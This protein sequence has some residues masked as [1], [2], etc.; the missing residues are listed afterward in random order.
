MEILQ[1]FEVSGYAQIKR[2]RRGG[3]WKFKL[4]NLFNS[5]SKLAE[6]G[7]GPPGK[8]HY[9]SDPPN[10]KLS[11]PRMQVQ[12]W[13]APESYQTIATNFPSHIS[14]IITLMKI[15]GRIKKKQQKVMRLFELKLNFKLFKLFLLSLFKVHF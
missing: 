10:E 9:P 12:Y 7:I 5:H 2:D 1:S 11:Y 6:I 15:K 4:T 13:L 3:G 14:Y 8:Q